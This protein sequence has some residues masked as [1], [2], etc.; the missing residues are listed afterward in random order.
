MDG[1]YKLLDLIFWKYI[2]KKSIIIWYF[3]SIRKYLYLRACPIAGSSGRTLI[4]FQIW[5][6]SIIWKISI[7]RLCKNPAYKIYGKNSSNIRHNTFLEDG[8]Y[9]KS[10][11]TLGMEKQAPTAYLSIYLILKW[12]EKYRLIIIYS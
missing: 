6:N 9:R 1:L 7:L 12:Y 8:Q 2:R 10:R 3:L 5:D 4:S 11:K